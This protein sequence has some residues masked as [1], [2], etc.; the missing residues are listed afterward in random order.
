MNNSARKRG[1]TLIEV[2]IAMAIVAILVAVALP[3]YRD[4]MR[5]SRRAEAQAY[6]MAVASR[7]QQFLLDTRG[8]AANLA[9]VGIAAPANVTAVYDVAVAAVVGPPPTFLLTAT[10]KAST[11]QV[12]ERCG[13]LGIDQTGAKTAALGTCW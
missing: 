5:K 12:Y 10:P 13:T 8:Y 3:S 7:Q 11:D 1:F 9:T 6:L 2:I 4:H